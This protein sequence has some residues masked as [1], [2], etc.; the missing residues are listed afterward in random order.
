MRHS[1]HRCLAAEQRMLEVVRTGRIQLSQ[2]PTRTD[3]P[4]TQTWKEW[5]K[6]VQEEEGKVSG[7]WH[8]GGTT[9]NRQAGESTSQFAHKEQNLSNSATNKSVPGLSCFPSG[10]QQLPETFHFVQRLPWDIGS[11]NN[12]RR[13]RQEISHSIHPHK[14]HLSC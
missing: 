2:D 10:Y 11:S 3:A 12:C 5:P 9:R 13:L 4:L 6:L 8:R 7:Q 14:P 1:D